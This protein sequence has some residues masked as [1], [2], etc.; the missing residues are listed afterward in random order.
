[1]LN[2]ILCGQDV[3]EQSSMELLISS[4]KQERLYTLMREKNS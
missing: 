2:Y 1:M 3:T 4:R